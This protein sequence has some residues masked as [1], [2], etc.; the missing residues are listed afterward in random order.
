MFVNE[1]IN[2]LS[3]SYQ[4]THLSSKVKALK[5]CYAP[6][7]DEISYYICPLS[8]PKPLGI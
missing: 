5:L 3:Q 2:Q 8:Q 4:G 7:T 1:L 6:T